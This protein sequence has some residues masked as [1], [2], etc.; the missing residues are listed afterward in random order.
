M[1]SPH[2]TRRS[3]NALGTATTA[4]FRH[5]DLATAVAVLVSC[6]NS[7]QQAETTLAP[8][9]AH[10]DCENP[11]APED[12]TRHDEASLLALDRLWV[13]VGRRAEAVVALAV[14]V[15][16]PAS[17][18]VALLSTLLLVLLDAPG[19]PET[20]VLQARLQRIASL[21]EVCEKPCGG[22]ISFPTALLLHCMA[23]GRFVS[24]ATTLQDA[25]ALLDCREDQAATGSATQ[26]TPATDRPF[27]I[28]ENETM[29][30]AYGSE[31]APT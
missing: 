31:M 11:Y 25:S 29:S 13:D 4:L 18:E 24:S 27:S 3:P 5:P 2:P 23:R 19:G 17:R 30:D 21:F 20:A 15:D 26:S 10:D 14:Q 9:K 6:L 28:S 22:E 1:L 16:D 7:A 8:S 12:W